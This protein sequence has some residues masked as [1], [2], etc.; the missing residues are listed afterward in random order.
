VFANAQFPYGGSVGK[1]IVDWMQQLLG[2]V[3]TG[4]LLVVVAMGYI[5]WQFNPAFTVPQRK[6]GIEEDVKVENKSEEGK[7]EGFTPVIAKTINDVYA[8]N[9]NNLKKNGEPIV[10]TPVNAKSDQPEL[11]LIERDEEPEPIIPPVKEKVLPIT[12]API[13]ETVQTILPKE[14]LPVRKTPKE[15][16]STAS[17]ELEIKESPIGPIEEEKVVEKEKGYESLPEYEPTL[18]LRD[19]RYPTL[20]LLET[21]GS[22]KIVQD[23]NE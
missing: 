6:K 16:A 19:Y 18:D 7:D 1:M 2:I 13:E 12:P 14:E 22:E 17:L 20:D 23:A 9:G 10:L 5:I 3:G 4:A 15:K 8:E 11:T 21:H